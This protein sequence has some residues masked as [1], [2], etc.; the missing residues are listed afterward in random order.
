VRSRLIPSS[1]FADVKGGAA[2]DK[3]RRV[4]VTREVT[5]KVL[6]AC[7]DA[8]WRLVV[9]LARFAGIRIPSE[10]LLLTWDDILWDEG[11]FRVRS[12]KTEHHEGKGERWV[13][14]FPELRP[15]LEA[16]FEAAPEGAVHL[17]GRRNDGVNLRTRLLRIIRRAGC[18]PWPKLFVNLRASRE[19]ELVAVYPLHVVCAW[20]GNSE[21][22]AHKHYLQVTDAD[23][24]HAAGMHQAVQK[25][26]QC[27]AEAVQNPVQSASAGA[28][29]EM[30]QAP[31]E[32][33]LVQILSSVVTRLQEA[34]VPP[35]GLEPLS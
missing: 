2:T 19:T 23:F 14:I 20:L 18:T 15:Y 30:T 10:L 24:R 13:P 31:D 25:A 34:G 35:R 33:G 5:A 21:L 12:P 4:F 11:K 27:G 17:V 16:A 1:P 8:G 22:I 3:A 6:D 7:P 32:R 29:Q 28:C 9:A 26:V